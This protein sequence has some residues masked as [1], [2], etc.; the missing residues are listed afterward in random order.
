MPFPAGPQKEDRAEI[1]EKPGK[2]ENTQKIS[3]AKIFLPQA[4]EDGI[5]SFTHKEVG[6][7]SHKFAHCSILVPLK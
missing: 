1:G 4:T 3:G 6:Q 2:S 5:H 7:T